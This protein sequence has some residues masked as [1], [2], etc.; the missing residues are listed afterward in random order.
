MLNFIGKLLFYLLFLLYCVAILFLP[1]LG[2]G[3]CIALFVFLVSGNFSLLIVVKVVFMI[4]S[5][6]GIQM[7]WVCNDTME[8]TYERLKK[9]IRKRP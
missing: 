7:L 1:F 8:Q 4:C 3:L 5:I 2:I 9:V 6:I